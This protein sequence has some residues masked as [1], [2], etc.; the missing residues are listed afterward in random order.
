VNARPEL[1][2][3]DITR[4]HSFTAENFDP[5]PLP[6]TVAPITRTPASFFV[7]HIGSYY[8]TFNPRYFESSLM[9]PM[10]SLATVALTSFLLKNQYFLR[11]GLADNLAGYG[12]VLNQWRAD[13][14]IAIAADEQNISQRNLFA[15]L[16]SKLF[17]LYK[18]AFGYPVLLPTSFDY[19]IFHD[20]PKLVF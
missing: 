20:F 9:L 11:L 2:D 16:A 4:T 6:L 8:L 17:D 19:C 14:G 10:T 15:D 12:G 7:C 18:I 5:A 1:A 13:F 3:D